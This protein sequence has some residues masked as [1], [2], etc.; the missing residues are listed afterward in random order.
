MF[1]GHYFDFN[2][3]HNEG[4]LVN[5]LSGKSFVMGVEHDKLEIHKSHV[6]DHKSEL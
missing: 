2:K 4:E 1:A 6:H 3:K 5:M